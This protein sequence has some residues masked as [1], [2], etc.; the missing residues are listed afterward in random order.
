MEHI[1]R[2]TVICPPANGDQCDDLPAVTSQMLA[3]LTED[4]RII[5]ADL[6]RVDEQRHIIQNIRR[7]FV[8]AC[9]HRV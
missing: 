4:I 1:T 2:L 7:Y 6:A 5:D 8:L 9:L 3:K